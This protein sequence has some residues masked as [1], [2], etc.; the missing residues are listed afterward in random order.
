MIKTKEYSAAVGKEL[1]AMWS[2]ARITN[3]ALFKEPVE[4]IKR[5]AGA[6]A[7][8]EVACGVPWWFVA[9]VHI[10]ESNGNFSKHLHNGDPLTKRT[11]QVPA[12]RPKAGKP[13]FPW[14]E[15]AVDALTMP[16]KSL[17]KITDWNIG[18][19]LWELERYNGLGYRLYHP[20]VPSPYLWSGTQFYTQGKYVADGKWSATAKDKQPG[21]VGLLK[22]LGVVR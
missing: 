21:C 6:Y 17:D 13:P 9:V 7:K 4:K 19:V 8:V 3:P 5:M 11:V 10:R 18:R 14:H 22:T 2:N 12:G 15:S 1:E 20:S 16:G